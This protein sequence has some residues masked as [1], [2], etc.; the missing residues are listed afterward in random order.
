MIVEIDILENVQIGPGSRHAWA[1][2]FL[3]A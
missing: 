1:I 3:I 2:I